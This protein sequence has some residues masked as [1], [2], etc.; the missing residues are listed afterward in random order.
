M[1]ERLSAGDHPTRR[2]RIQETT[3]PFSLND[4]QELPKSLRSKHAPKADAVMLTLKT[5]LDR[6]SAA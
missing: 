6:G 5:I 3:M 2:F 4:L 1:Y